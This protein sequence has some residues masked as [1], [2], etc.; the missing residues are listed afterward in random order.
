[1]LPVMALVHLMKQMIIII[2]KTKSWKIFTFSSIFYH[3]KLTWLK[4]AL[5]LTFTV[6]C[7]LVVVLESN[8][9]YNIVLL[10]YS[11]IKY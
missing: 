3:Q 10:W 5:F 9:F 6:L 2:A 7:W 4:L 1:M 8:L 11:V